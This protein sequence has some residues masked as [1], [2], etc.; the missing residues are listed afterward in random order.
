MGHLVFPAFPNTTENTVSKPERPLSG[1]NIFKMFSLKI[2]EIKE[3][4]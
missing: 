1:N 3:S 4:D 2:V